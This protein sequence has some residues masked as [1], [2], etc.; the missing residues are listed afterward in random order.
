MVIRHQVRIGISRSGKSEA[1]R[2]TALRHAKARDR[3]LIVIDPH[4]TLAKKLLLDFAKLGMLKRVIY[5]RLSD[6]D[7]TPSYDWLVPSKDSDPYQRVAQ[8]EQGVRDFVTLLMR[9][10]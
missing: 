9:R 2:V 1:A 3:A 10:R 7:L 4:G 6:T 5:D 8:N